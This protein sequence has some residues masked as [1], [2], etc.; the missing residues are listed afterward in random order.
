MAAARISQAER[1]AR[2]IA[3]HPGATVKEARGHGRTGEHGLTKST[4][5]G[6]ELI[7]SFRLDKIAGRA[8]AEVE[9]EAGEGARVEVAIRDK[10]GNSIN[11]WSGKGYSLSGLQDHLRANNGNWRQALLDAVAGSRY[12]AQVRALLAQGGLEFQLFAQ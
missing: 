3:R 8:L 11:L 7:Y 10:A 4:L 2:Y 12:E 9:R 1:I 5:G 6:G